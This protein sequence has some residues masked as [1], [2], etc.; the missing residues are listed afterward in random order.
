MHAAQKLDKP[1]A[2]CASWH[3][4]CLDDAQAAK[5]VTASAY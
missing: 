4:T 1:W 2:K 5:I 3:P